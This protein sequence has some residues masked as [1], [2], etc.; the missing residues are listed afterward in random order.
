MSLTL[1]GS[2]TV[3]AAK[4]ANAHDFIEEFPGGYQT[5]VGERGQSLSGVVRVGAAAVVVGGINMTDD[6]QLG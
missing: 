6:T 1:N 4:K 5:L 2:R 3:E